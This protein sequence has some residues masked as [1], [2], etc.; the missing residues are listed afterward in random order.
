MRVLQAYLQIVIVLLIC[1]YFTTNL[2]NTLSK[3]CVKIQVM[4]V[5]RKIPFHY[6]LYAV[7]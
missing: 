3:L 5:L 2:L 1:C 6:S 4:L 7:S